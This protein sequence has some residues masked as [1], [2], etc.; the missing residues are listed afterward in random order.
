[1]RGAGGCGATRRAG[2]AGERPAETAEGGTATG[3][4]AAGT[5]VVRTV[6]AAVGAV[7]TGCDD[8]AG[9]ET[10]RAGIGAATGGAPTDTAEVG[11][12]LVTAGAT[13]V[14]RLTAAGGAIAGFSTV[15]YVAWDAAG[16]GAAGGAAASFFWVIAFSTSP[17]REMFERSILVLISSSPR[18]GRE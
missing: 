3:V 5:G 6:G 9:A 1:M 4:C 13:V 12:G 16:R 17:G 2:A 15:G 14:G 8:A 18:R 11:A 10:G 7:V